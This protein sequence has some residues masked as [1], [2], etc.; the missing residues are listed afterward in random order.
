MHS[1]TI[2]PDAS[3]TPAAALLRLAVRSSRLRTT[4]RQRS[5][6]PI[7]RVLCVV[8][9]AEPTASLERACV[10]RGADPSTDY[11][12]ADPTLRCDQLSRYHL[13]DSVRDDYINL[14][15]ARAKVRNAFSARAPTK[16]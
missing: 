16:P 8:N 11:P 4:T 12:T 5:D 15:E 14:P 3:S 13:N 1:P 2:I 7:I 6:P 10:C 9:D